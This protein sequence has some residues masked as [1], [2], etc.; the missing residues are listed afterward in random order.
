MKSG[1][2]DYTRLTLAE[3]ESGLVAVAA[4]VRSTFSRLDT[5]QLNWQVGADR[6]SVAQCLDHLLAANRLMLRAA[7][8]ALAGS[9]PRSVWQRLPILPA[10]LGRMLIRSQSPGATRRFTAP[11]QAHPASSGIEA[12][13]VQRFLAQHQDA[14]ARLQALD[15]DRAARAI[16][17]SP[18]IKV[19]TYSVLDGW[20]LIL[21]HDRRHV[22][23]AHGVMRSPGFPASPSAG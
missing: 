7:D 21:A 8:D 16:M 13:I 9:A 19:V 14:V 11:V 18:F 6:W 1:G 12:D 15:A 20:R 23:Q 17:T 10:V 2:V 22:Q 5:R 4:E 3:V